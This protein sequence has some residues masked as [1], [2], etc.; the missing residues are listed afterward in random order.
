[1]KKMSTDG[2]D[3]FLSAMMAD[4]D[5]A[6]L[7]HADKIIDKLGGNAAEICSALDLSLDE[8]QNG[9]RRILAADVIRFLNYCAKTLNADDFGLRLSELSSLAIL[10]PVWPLIQHA[11]S[12][13]QVLM[14]MERYIALYTQAMYI[15]SETYP[16]GI[17]LNFS[18]LGSDRTRDRQVIENGFGVL[19]RSIKLMVG[20]PNWHPPLIHFRHAQPKNMALHRQ[21][22]GPNIDF[23]QD[24]NCICFDNIFISRSII[25]ADAEIRKIHLIEADD[26]FQKLK[27]TAIRKIEI[28]VRELLPSGTCSLHNVAHSLHM[29]DRSLQRILESSS[30]SFSSILKRVKKDHALN[31]LRQSDL[32]LIQI[33]EILGYKNLTSFGRAFKKLHGKKLS[34][35][36][37]QN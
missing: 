8:I 7:Q 12:V 3:P 30:V 32:S 29:S 37:K 17:K 33:S 23:N 9:S 6:T 20:A 24:N 31:Y 1:M 26:A 10:G 18:I 22:L 21:I 11:A 28:A 34:D 4:V 27:T 14:D 19:C 2:H 15:K 35:I 5:A 16:G 25:N 36:R 13:S